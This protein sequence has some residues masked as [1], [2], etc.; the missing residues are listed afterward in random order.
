MINNKYK[1]KKKLKTISP[2]TLTDKDSSITDFFIKK[3]VSEPNGK[4]P[5]SLHVCVNGK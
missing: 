5:S 1:I 2:K 4:L 3:L